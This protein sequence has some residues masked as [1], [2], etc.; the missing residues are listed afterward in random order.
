MPGLINAQSDNEHEARDA[1][2]RGSPGAL[3]SAVSMLLGEGSTLKKTAGCWIERMGAREVKKR[4][5]PDTRG[6]QG[7][8]TSYL[9]RKVILFKNNRTGAPGGSPSKD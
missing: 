7:S 5:G 4:K 2:Q 9:R 1:G 8:E 6:R 3:R